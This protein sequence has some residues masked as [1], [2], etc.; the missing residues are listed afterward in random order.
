MVSTECQCLIFDWFIAG[1]TLCRVITFNLLLKIWIGCTQLTPWDNPQDSAS[2]NLFYLNDYTLYDLLWT[3]LFACHIRMSTTTNE[4]SM[5]GWGLCAN[6]RYLS[7]SDH[8][9]KHSWA[10]VLTKVFVTGSLCHRLNTT[11]DD[12][13]TSHIHSRILAPTS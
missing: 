5:I 10:P 2:W 13:Q 12:A 3:V 4:R 7:V 11:D 1:K 9:F 8:E 6:R